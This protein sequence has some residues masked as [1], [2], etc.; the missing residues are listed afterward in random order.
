V[1][2][3][4]GDKGYEQVRP[5]LERTEAGERSTFEYHIKDRDIISTVV[6]H[7]GPDGKVDGSLV[8]AQDVTELVAARAALD[9]ERARRTLEAEL[10]HHAVELGA[11]SDSFHEAL[12]R[13]VEKVCQMTDWPVGHVYE[14]SP[15]NPDEL[16]PT[17]IWHLTNPGKYSF[18][19]EVTERTKFSKGVGLPGRI[20][21]SGEPAWIKNVEVD[22][23]FP[24]TKLAE[25]LGVKGAFGF[26][27][28][29]G[30]D[31]V[32]VLEF[33]ADTEMAPDQSLL[34]IMHHLGEQLGRVF[35]RKRAEENLKRAHE[36]TR[37]KNQELEKILEELTATQTELI[38]SGKMAVLGKLTAGV[39]HELNTP[40]GA[41]KSAADVSG[42]CISK[43]NDVVKHSSSLQE[44]VGN[45]KFQQSL[46][47]LDDSSKNLGA[48]SDRISTIVKSLR[49]FAR[50][51]EAE[52]Q[53]ANLHEGIESTLI[54]IQHATKEGTRIVKKFGNLP[55]C[56]CN[57]GDINQVFM[58]LLTNAVEAV[59]EEGVVTIRTSADEAKIYVEIEDTGRGIPSESLETIFDL[60]FTTRDR[61]IGVGL[62]LPTAYSIIQK[63]HGE[64]VVE[65]GVGQGSKF[66][67]ILPR[68]SL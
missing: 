68:R 22:P 13:I 9:S 20:L 48:G 16:V 59:E 55:D 67:I 12:Q 21:K 35:E 53:R 24:R 66:T 4:L 65:S 3:L 56:Y 18:F 30:G 17:N 29:V 62:G 36:E 11:E 6:P 33:F 32:A 41:I 49:S 64:L 1:R 46:T 19:R 37:K 60:N 51:D 10:L 38:Q 8:L 63:H 2:D 47:I 27:V 23:N 61:R 58:T 45:P 43:I 34:S 28:K 50:L 39:A 42:R 7:Y 25:N 52:F 57:A 15:V 44:I 54:L 31:V 26:P 14:P 5:N 40:V